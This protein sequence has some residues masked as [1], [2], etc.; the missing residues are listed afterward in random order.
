MM[1]MKGASVSPWSTAEIILR[2]EVS[3]PD[4]QAIDR[5]FLY[6]IIIPL[7]VSLEIQ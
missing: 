6:S 3:P 2:K 7:D 1:K 4:D 5:V